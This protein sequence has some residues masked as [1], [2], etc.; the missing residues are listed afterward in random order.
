M[1]IVETDIQYRL[2]G[3]AANADL[4][5][6]LGGIMS[7][8]AADLATPANNAW[9]DVPGSEAAAGRTEYRCFYV[10]NGHASLTLQDAY[11]E[12]TTQ[13]QAAVAIGLD[14][15]G[16]GDGA[17]TGVATT[18]ANE[19]TAPTGVTFSAVNAGDRL[20]IG[21]LGP[22]QAIAVWEK[23][24]VEAGEAIKNTDQRAWTAGGDTAA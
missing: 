23:R 12:L 10:R 15:A 11:V 9:D 19:T 17:T 18:V 13:S 14:P 2:S 22:G 21:D 24:I 3:G 7:S 16:I 1:P 5:A 4:D 8:T 20:T 6:S